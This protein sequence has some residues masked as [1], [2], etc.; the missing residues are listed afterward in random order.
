[1]RDP[2]ELREVLAGVTGSR[3]EGGPIPIGGGCIHEAFRFGEFFV[4]CNTPS[5]LGMFRAEERG[6][7]ALRETGTI[8]IP[9]PICAGRTSSQA[10]LVLEHLPLGGDRARAQ[11][12]LG[13]QLAAMHGC[14]APEFG[15]DHDNYIG[16]TPQPNR[17][18]TSWITFLREERLRHMFGLAEG[19]GFRISGGSQLLDH[20]ER[21]FEE[22]EPVPSPLHGDL[23]GGNADA[24]QDGTP[25]V[26]D[27]AFYHGDREA[28][29]A[30][31]T[32]F[33]GFGPAF[34][35]AYQEAWPLPAGHERRR[36]LYNLYHILNHAILFGGGYA[37]QAQEMTDGLLRS[38]S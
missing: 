33:G 27:P 35:A 19:R 23:W 24:L 22:G 7:R 15:A 11:E 10:Y 29:L 12:E 25:V 38:I 20:L 4:K 34:H 2:E 28:D 37:R 17:R 14:V 9:A 16:A 31:T 3:P 26:F 13:R 21:F 32:L 8:R 1:M 36:D 6:L 30:M 18:R 5:N